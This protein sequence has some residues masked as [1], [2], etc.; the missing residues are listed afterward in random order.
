[1]K[2]YK[3]LLLPILLFPFVTSCSK[4]ESIEGP[5][6]LNPN[7]AGVSLTRA[8]INTSSDLTAIGIYAVNYDKT[9]STYG[10]WPKG[11]YGKYAHQNNDPFTPASADQTIWLNP[12]VAIIYSFHPA[13]DNTTSIS[14]GNASPSDA[15]VTTPI[16]CIPIPE[17]TIV[18]APTISGT[19]ST[20][21]FTTAEKDYMY[22][23]KYDDSLPDNDKF[24]TTQPVADNGR[25]A[26]S[27]GNQVS[28]GLKHAFSQIRLAIKKGNY[29]VN[30]IV[31]N[32]TYTR[33]MKILAAPENTNYAVKMQL[34]N[35]QFTGLAD[36]AEHAYEYDL[37]KL[38]NG[39]YQLTGD[40]S[41]DIIITNYSLPNATAPLTISVTVDDKVMSITYNDDPEWLPGKIYTYAISINGT[42]LKFSGVSIVD[43]NT[44]ADN[45]TSGTL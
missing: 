34:T 19:V 28:I 42:G 4:E 2:P 7:V 5:V 26:G 12:E 37:S 45:N 11:T 41:N 31:S 38:T 24:T 17:G 6:S 13:A 23:V 18:L 1:M 20:F 40:A 32:V 8:G 9:Q 21:D 22:G 16:P 14:D 43:W 33:S 44:P 25:A 15:S 10:E 39:G 30:P 29:P 35:G 27:F 3:Y 36:V